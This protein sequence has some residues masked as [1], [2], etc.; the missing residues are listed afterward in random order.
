MT[1]GFMTD[2]KLQAIPN[3]VEGKILLVD[4]NLQDL[5]F[6]TVVLYR[7]GYQVVPCDSYEAAQRWLASTTFD[8]VVL[9]Q[10][11]P[12]FE[13]RKVLEAAVK[14]NRRTP[15]LVM[16]HWVDMSIYVEAMGLGAVDYL[17]KSVDPSEMV[18]AIKHHLG[19]G[20]QPRLTRL[21]GAGQEEHADSAASDP[22]H[23]LDFGGPGN[24]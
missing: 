9:S 20:N 6:Y 13:G 1:F 23:P 15:V 14:P 11:G 18:R 21:E 4:D 10:G 19:H 5:G 7:Q 16:A 3:L 8:L 12:V 17:E 22:P 24:C 2:P